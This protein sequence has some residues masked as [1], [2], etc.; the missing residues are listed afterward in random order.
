MNEKMHHNY[1]KYVLHMKKTHKKTKKTEKK[2][3]IVSQNQSW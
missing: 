3:A 1:E 2:L